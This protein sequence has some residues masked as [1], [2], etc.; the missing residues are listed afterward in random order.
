MEEK[1]VKGIVKLAINGDKKMETEALLY[2]GLALHR[3]INTGAK[4]NTWV[5]SHVSSGDLIASARISKVIALKWLMQSGDLFDW[6]GPIAD[7]ILAPG[8]TLTQDHHERALAV[9]ECRPYR[10]AA[11]NLTGPEAVME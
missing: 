5:L 4:P 2:K 6:S 11:S 10:H 3:P 8:H 9:L 1:P 7:R